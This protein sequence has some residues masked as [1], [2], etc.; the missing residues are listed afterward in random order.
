MKPIRHELLN[1]IDIGFNPNPRQSPE[2]LSV[3]ARPLGAP[4]AREKARVPR[5]RRAAQINRKE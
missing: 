1:S 4:P 2:T 3:T 5:E